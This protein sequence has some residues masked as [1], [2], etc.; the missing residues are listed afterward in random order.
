MFEEYVLASKFCE[1]MGIREN[2]EK[3]KNTVNAFVTGYNL[4]Q[5]GYWYGADVVPDVEEG[6]SKEVIVSVFRSHNQE[7]YCFSAQYLNVMSLT[8]YDDSETVNTG[9]YSVREHSDYDGC[10]SPIYLA[11]GD[12]ITGWQY[13]PKPRTL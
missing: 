9:W 1:Q 12:K 5:N 6:D 11:D 2:S 13:L 8:N 4:G 7:T 3:W 10:Y